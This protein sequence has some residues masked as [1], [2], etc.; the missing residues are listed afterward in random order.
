M[1][2]FDIVQAII[3]IL[4]ALVPWL[5]SDCQ[6]YIKAIIALAILLLSV[7]VSWL[8]LYVKLRNSTKSLKASNKKRQEI[9]IKHN[10]LSIQFSEKIEKEQKYRKFIKSMTFAFLIA[11]ETEDKLKIEN[12][13]RIFLLE[14]ERLEDGGVS[15]GKIHQNR[16]DYQ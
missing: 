1:N 8:R 9:E 4:L 12:V 5:I 2:A 15:D 11:L 7:I 14:Q 10:A 13:Y 3:T 16:E 6:W